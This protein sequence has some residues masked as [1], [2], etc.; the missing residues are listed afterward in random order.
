MTWACVAAA[1]VML[2]QQECIAQ[3]VRLLEEAHQQG[4]ARAARAAVADPGSRRAT[5]Q[6]EAVA[7]EAARRAERESLI[8]EMRDNL[9]DLAGSMRWPPRPPTKA[10]PVQLHCCVSHTE[11]IWR[12]MPGPQSL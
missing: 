11:C 1:Q 5:A 10:Q 8:G 6:Q 7:R 9:L 2:A 4:C 12:G 3:R